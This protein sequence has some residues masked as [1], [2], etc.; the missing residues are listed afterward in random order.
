MSVR[1]AAGHHTRVQIELERDITTNLTHRMTVMRA[2]EVSLGKI[3]CALHIDFWIDV[4][5]SQ[6]SVLQYPFPAST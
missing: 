5:V 6:S 2:I 1:G 4:Q 3:H